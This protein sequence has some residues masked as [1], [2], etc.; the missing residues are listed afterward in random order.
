MN[1][2]THFTRFAAI[3][4]SGA[5]GERQRGIAIAMC[6]LGD[7]APVLIPPPGRAWSRAQAREWMLDQATNASPTLIGLDLSPAL[8][9]DDAGCYFPEW[10]ET[11]ADARRLWKLVDAMSAEDPH[12]AAISFLRHPEVSRH[13]RIQQI[14]GD[15]FPGGR[16]RLRLCEERQRDMQLLPSSCF[17]LVGP[18]QVGKSSLTGMRVLHQLGGRLPVWPFDAAPSAGPLIVEIYTS[19]AARE[20]GLPRGRSKMRDASSLADALRKLGVTQDHAPLARYDDHATDAILTAAWMRRNAQSAALWNP[21]GLDKV[22]STEGWTFG[23][24]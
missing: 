2:P 19:L 6:E 22:A 18:A 11:P 7:D 10:D 20:A 9:F 16:G 24:S 8:P 13:F 23:V 3:D 4:W 17:N 1:A 21:A 15:L 5:K 12:E 14:A